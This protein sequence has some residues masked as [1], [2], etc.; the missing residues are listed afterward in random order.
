M[1]GEFTKV[2]CKCKNEQVIFSKPASTVRCLVCKEVLVEPTGG[3]GKP[4]TRAPGKALDTQQGIPSRAQAGTLKDTGR[5]PQ[6]H[7]QAG[8]K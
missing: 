5:H 6:G 4:R 8:N 1:P 7:R 2:R 3:R